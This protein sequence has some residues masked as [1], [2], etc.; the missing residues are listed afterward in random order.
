MLHH[1]MLIT[2]LKTLKTTEQCWQQMVLMAPIGIHNSVSSPAPPL[3]NLKLHFRYI[4]WPVTVQWSRAQIDLTTRLQNQCFVPRDVSRF[5][6]PSLSFPSTALAETSSPVQCLATI[7]YLCDF[8]MTPVMDVYIK[9]L[10]LCSLSQSCEMS[11]LLHGAKSSNKILPQEK[12]VNID[13]FG[14]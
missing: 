1:S 12:R 6:N 7:I 4:V 9:V 13:N 10:M 2:T 3:L 14:T 11:I 8:T 5:L